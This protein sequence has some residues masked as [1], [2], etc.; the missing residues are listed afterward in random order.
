MWE[1]WSF[2]AWKLQGNLKSTT[3][4]FI[5]EFSK[6]Y[7]FHTKFWKLQHKIYP[8]TFE[9]YYFFQISQNSNKIWKP[10]QIIENS[11][12]PEDET[13]SFSM[14]ILANDFFEPWKDK[15]HLRVLRFMWAWN[16]SSFNYKKNRWKLK[17]PII[18]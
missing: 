11:K 14:T 12:I 4:N 9:I 13:A 18:L 2:Q 3:R 5:L 15:S 8:L 6:S 1:F 7:K 10:Q 16:I 17:S